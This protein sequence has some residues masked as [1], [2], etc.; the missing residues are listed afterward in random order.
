MEITLSAFD[1]GYITFMVL[2]SL[3]AFGVMRFN[4]QADKER[5]AIDKAR[6]EIERERENLRGEEYALV[7]KQQRLEFEQAQFKKYR[8]KL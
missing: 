1:L 5:R 2:L 4:A 7:A 8:K 6:K 3:F